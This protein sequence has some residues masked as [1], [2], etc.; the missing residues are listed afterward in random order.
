MTPRDRALFLA[1]RLRKHEEAVRRSANLAVEFGGVDS[2]ESHKEWSRVL[3]ALLKQEDSTRGFHQEKSLVGWKARSQT[4]KRNWEQMARSDAILRRWPAR[5]WKVPEE[6]RSFAEARWIKAGGVLTKGMM[7]APS[8]DPLWAEISDY[9]VPWELLLAGEWRDWVQAWSREDLESI[10]GLN[11]KPIGWLAGR[12]TPP[13]SAQ[14][15]S[16][17]MDPAVKAKLLAEL[18][19]M[20][21]RLAGRKTPHEAAHEAAE[22]VRAELAKRAGL[23]APE[24]QPY[25]P[26]AKPIPH[27]G[28]V[29]DLPWTGDPLRPEQFSWMD[30]VLP[31]ACAK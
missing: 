14:V 24:P 29:I 6:M 4:P 1:E 11:V 31:M 17:R 7:I 16:P 18:G 27:E 10:A 28:P 2:H 26:K 25:I 15:T 8:L 9:G 19:A 21:A 13:Q 30:P 3:T 23:P 5:E 20:K 22:K 12:L